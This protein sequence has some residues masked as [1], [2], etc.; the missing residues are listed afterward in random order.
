VAGTGVLA[1]Y[2]R[3]LRQRDFR[4]LVIGFIVDQSANWAN[5]VV[6]TVYIFSRTHS[7]TW[8][9]AMMIAR[10][11]AGVLA[12]GPAGVI[13]DRYD[14]HTVMIWSAL[15]AT[16]ISLGIVGVVATDGPLGVLLVLYMALQAACSPN[17]ACSG[18][19]LPEVVPER[20]LVAANGLFGMLEGLVGVIGPGIGGVITLLGDPVYGA[21]LNTASFVLA[22]G[23]YR[24]LRV[25]SRGGAEAGTNML[26]QWVDGIGT[27]VRYRTAV[28][29]VLFMLLDS[30]AVM[31]ASLLYAPLSFHVGGGE[32]GIG[33]LVAA[34]AGGGLLSAPL[35]SKLA[36][37][38]R[39]STVVYGAIVLQCVPLYVSYLMP[40]VYL[41]GV[42]QVIAGAGMTVV[43]VLA[44]TALQRDLPRAILGRAL[45]TVDGLFLLTVVLG[46]VLTNLA[47][48]AWGLGVTLAV[49]A[50][51][52]PVVGLLGLPG[53]RVGDREGAARMAALAARIDLLQG[54]AL[55]EG[56]TR[57][58]LESLASAARVRDVPSG[59]P[60]IRQGE[61]AD[62]LWVLESGQLDVRHT[63]DGV[64]VVL[65]SVQAPAYVGE[66]GLI[67]AAPRSATVVTAGDCRLL[68]ID[69]EEFSAAL[70]AA[71]LSS[72]ATSL[73]GVRLSRT[74]AAARPERAA[75]AQA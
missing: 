14:R 40:N 73:A 56:A 5:S 27:L 10:C 1:G 52:T 45:A 16:A 57:A 63:V 15:I 21:W 29:L 12:S 69:A 31:A 23:I 44:F 24:L 26:K 22:A 54:L 13:A 64:E 32:S 72:S 3:T 53:L 61:S 34:G 74:P 8:L 18:A 35:A 59:E 19:L 42:F 41:A 75:L 38:P 43:D 20:D 65:P 7:V 6:L 17:R 46:S 71:P 49:I 55:F 33:L 47:Y 68:R 67:N 60:I 66:L 36:G 2:R 37:S 4:L 11:V 70:R 28:A 30:L 50:F 25:R 48:D 9:T 58:T 62:A 51:G 39:M